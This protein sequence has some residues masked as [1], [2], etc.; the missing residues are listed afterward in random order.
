MPA[1]PN[2]NDVH[3]RYKTVKS[4]TGYRDFTEGQRPQQKISKLT[5]VDTAHLITLKW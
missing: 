2:G 3:L 5:V 4:L 1:M